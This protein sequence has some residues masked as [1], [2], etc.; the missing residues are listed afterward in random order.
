LIRVPW[1]VLDRMIDVA[2]EVDDLGV[3]EFIEGV[4]DL[5]RKPEKRN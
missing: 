4:A 5:V 1:G 3:V 2:D